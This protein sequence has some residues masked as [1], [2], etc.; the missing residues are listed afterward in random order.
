MREIRIKE[1]RKKEEEKG[2]LKIK[3]ETNMTIKEA[4][5]AVM[6]IWQNMINQANQ[7]G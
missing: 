3:P 1:I 4:N 5:L 6:Q 7:E 2:Y